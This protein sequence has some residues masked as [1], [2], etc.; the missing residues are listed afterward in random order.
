MINGTLSTRSGDDEKL[1]HMFNRAK[2]NASM[3]ILTPFKW[4]YMTKCCVELE[5]TVLD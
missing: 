5:E 1:K 2:L 4:H 3:R